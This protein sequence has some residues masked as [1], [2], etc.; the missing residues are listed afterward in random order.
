MSVGPKW[1][2]LQFWINL[3]P[4]LLSQTFKIEFFNCIPNHRKPKQRYYFSFEVFSISL[5]VL[6]CAL[7]H[8]ALII[9]WVLPAGLRLVFHW[10]FA[11]TIWELISAY[12]GQFKCTTDAR[13]WC[14]R[15]QL[16]TQTLLAVYFAL[17]PILEV[18]WPDIHLVCLGCRRN[19]FKICVE[20]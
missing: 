11:G 1:P 20:H 2:F 6:S 5:R 12:L 3:M 9:N 16:I 19:H 17:T 8:T 15:R 14:Q 18:T 7:W 13:W 10:T 4:L